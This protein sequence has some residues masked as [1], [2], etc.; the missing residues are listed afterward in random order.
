MSFAFA[1]DDNLLNVLCADFQQAIID[2]LVPRRFAAATEYG[3]DTVT[4]SGGVSCKSELRKA[5]GHEC[6]ARPDS[7]SKVTSRGWHG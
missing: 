5:I 1:K 4:V 7:N 2:V 6:V 3:V